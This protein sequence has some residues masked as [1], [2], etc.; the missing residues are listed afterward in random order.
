MQAYIDMSSPTNSENTRSLQATS[1]AV[2]VLTEHAISLA[3]GSCWWAFW[4]L[5][6]KYRLNVP[7][8]RSELRAILRGGMLLN[9][10]NAERFFVEF[11]LGSVMRSSP[12]PGNTGPDRHTATPPQITE[13]SSGPQDVEISP[14]SGVRVPHLVVREEFGES[15][16]ISIS[17]TPGHGTDTDGDQTELWPPV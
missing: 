10:K 9:H 2:D 4:D 14:K 8:I 13:A 1:D 16:G 11:G 12:A 7:A 17:L 5:H 15:V 6:S 3:I